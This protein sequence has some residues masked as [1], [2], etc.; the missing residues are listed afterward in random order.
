MK[1]PTREEIRRKALELYFSENPYA[2]TTPEDYELKE[3]GYWERARRILMRG[4]VP[5]EEEEEK[6]LER[7]Y[8]IGRLQNEILPELQRLL[9]RARDLGIAENVIASIEDLLD[10]AR[11]SLGLKTIEELESKIM[12]YEMKIKE[13]NEKLSEYAENVLKKFPRYLTP[14]EI[15]ALWISSIKYY[16]EPE[17]IEKYKDK[18]IEDLKK[19][20]FKSISEAETYAKN[21]VDLYVRKLKSEKEYNKFKEEFEMALRIRG[22]TPSISEY[23]EFE[24]T[25]KKLLQKGAKPETISEELKKLAERIAKRKGKKPKAVEVKGAVTPAYTIPKYLIGVMPPIIPVTRKY[26]LTKKCPICGSPM[27]SVIARDEGVNKI[28]YYCTNPKCT[29]IEKK[30]LE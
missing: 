28:I 3:G 29:Y 9:Q 15:E 4:E 22:V 20:P 14:S 13:L 19:R 16:G 8:E 6:E 18:F 10:D 25:Y 27:S 30:V 2:T 21:L 26:P 1:L 7:A 5:P 12:E 11:R 24:K 17:G 23:D